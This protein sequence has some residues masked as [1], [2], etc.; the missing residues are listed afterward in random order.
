MI[1]ERSADSRN[2]SS[3]NSITADALRCR[4]PFDFTDKNP[5]SGINYYRLKIIDIGGKVSYSSIVALLN[6]V[7]GFEIISLTPN[8]AVGNNITLNISS[9]IALKI[10]LAIFDMQGKLVNRQTAAVIAGFT[11]IPMQV[12]KLAA[13]SYTIQAIIADEKP[14]VIRFVKQ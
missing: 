7:R 3:I 6:A 10:N 8:P 5:L 13:G 11:A 9:A 4:Q 12:G 1:L 14:K 2:F